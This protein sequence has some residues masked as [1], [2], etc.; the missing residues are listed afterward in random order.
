[1]TV[2]GRKGALRHCEEGELETFMTF[3][4]GGRELNHGN[5]N[6]NEGDLH[7]TH[8]ETRLIKTWELVSEKQATP[9]RCSVPIHLNHAF[10]CSSVN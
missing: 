8:V 10:L 3:Q 6:G 9:H 4:W 5:A 2:I 7:G 1:M